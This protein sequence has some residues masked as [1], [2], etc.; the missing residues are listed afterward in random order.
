M[1]PERDVDPAELYDRERLAFVAFLRSLTPEQL[2]LGVPATPLWMVHDVLAHVVAITAD[3]NAQRFGGAADD[4]QAWTA[5]QIDERRD[6]SVDELAAEWDREAPTFTDGLRVFGYGFG[7]HYLG[8]LLQHVGDAHHAVGR[9]PVR[10]DLPLTIALDFYLESFEETIVGAGLG[11]VEV[12]AL[13]ADGRPG[14]EFV[15]GDRDVIARVRAS[16]WELFRALGGRRTMA[17]VRALGWADPE[18]SEPVI[19]VMSRYPMPDV[20]L[21]E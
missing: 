15:L 14:E 6:R 17:Q 8:D 1:V 11:A 3:L 21:G 7:A 9:S 2:A 12:V 19:A 4:P 5:R 10:D 16:R 18:R 20:P 13:E